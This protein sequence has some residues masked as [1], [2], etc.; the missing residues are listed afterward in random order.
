LATTLPTDHANAA[1]ITSAN[2]INVTVAPLASWSAAS[3]TMPTAAMTA[4]TR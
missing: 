3:K 1:T 2:P 4:P